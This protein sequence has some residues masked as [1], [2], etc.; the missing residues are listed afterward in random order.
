MCTLIL[1]DV[2]GSLNHPLWSSGPTKIPRFRYSLC[3]SLGVGCWTT[4]LASLCLD[5][6]SYKLEWWSYVPHIVALKWSKCLCFQLCPSTWG[7]EI[8]KEQKIAWAHSS[9][10][11]AVRV[12]DWW[13][14]SCCWNS[15]I[16]QDV[17]CALTLNCPLQVPVLKACPQLV[18]LFWFPKK[19]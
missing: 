2:F 19:L 4:Y 18:S 14:L 12:S 7:W 8:Y 11:R 5:F 17:H 10:G 9:T 6:L 13:W 1:P 15:D 16:T 3:L